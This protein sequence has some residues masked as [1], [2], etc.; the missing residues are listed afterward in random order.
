M[1]VAAIVAISRCASS[2][3]FVT[4]TSAATG[5]AAD[6]IAIGE[7]SG[8][9]MSHYSWRASTPRGD[10]NCTADAMRHYPVC[11]PVAP[12]NARLDK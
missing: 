2:A 1:A 7:V 6:Q 3:D 11:T 8:S 5:I 10:Y 9:A 4:S 12:D